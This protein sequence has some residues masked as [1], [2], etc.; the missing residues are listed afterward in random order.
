M[1]SKQPVLWK[2]RILVPFW[3]IRICLM[4]F[5]IAASAWALKVLKDD[6]DR[7]APAIGVVAVFMLLIIVVL[8]LDILAIL[9]FLR[10]ALHPGT[11]L[12]MNSIQTGFWAGVLIM[13][14]VAIARGASAVGIGFSAFVL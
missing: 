6:P 9:L 2:K 1:A 13:D 5:I 3:I 14:V 12:I 10:D 4:I 11:F 7:T 8:L